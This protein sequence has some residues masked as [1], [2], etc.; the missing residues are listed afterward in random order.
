MW[1]MVCEMKESR[2]EGRMFPLVNN[3]AVEECEALTVGAP[4]WNCSS[5]K[6]VG[7]TGNGE[8]WKFGGKRAGRYDADW[9]CW[10]VEQC[11]GDTYGRSWGRS[12]ECTC[13]GG[14]VVEGACEGLRGGRQEK[15]LFVER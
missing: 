7:R 12:E 3:S 10:D 14:D 11:K 8:K 13:V 6:E 2:G 1:R 4:V 9:C 15:V 5:G